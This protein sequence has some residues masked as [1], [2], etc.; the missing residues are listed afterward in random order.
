MCTH[1]KF[2]F[3]SG[4][5]WE[6][7]NYCIPI[8]IIAILYIASY[9][10]LCIYIYIC[11]IFKVL[12]EFTQLTNLDLLETFGYG[13]NKY[14][15]RLNALKRQQNNENKIIE[16]ICSEATTATSTEPYIVN[17][18]IYITLGLLIFV[19]DLQMGSHDSEILLV[20]C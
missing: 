4:E 20:Y 12:A 2:A 9:Y 7:V 15:V 11:L 1:A 17:V 18:R 5:V 13:V 10:S 3:R 19:N 8:Y 6:C 16:V 14:T